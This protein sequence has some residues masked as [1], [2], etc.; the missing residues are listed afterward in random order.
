MCVRGGGGGRDG[1]P[2]V[3]SS[4]QHVG[5]SKLVVWKKKLKEVSISRVYG[6]I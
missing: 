1:S 6:W 5:T 2:K 3:F 4:P